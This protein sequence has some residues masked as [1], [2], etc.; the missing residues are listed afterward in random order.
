MRFQLPNETPPDFK[1]EAT[2]TA[3]LLK[4]KMPVA[5]IKGLANDHINKSLINKI[6]FYNLIVYLHYLCLSY[7]NKY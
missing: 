4:R 1:T 6:N 2:K 3:S 7:Y 5:V